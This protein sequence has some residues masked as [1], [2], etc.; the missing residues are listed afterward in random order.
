M[1]ELARKVSAA[2]V[3]VSL[4]GGGAAG[5]K[6]N[7]RPPVAIPSEFRGTE[8]TVPTDQTSMAI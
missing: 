5:Q 7:E 6:K 3:V 1:I 2:I 8:T 4:L